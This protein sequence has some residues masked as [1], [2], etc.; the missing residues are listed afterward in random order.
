MIPTCIKQHNCVFGRIAPC[1]TFD[2]SVLSRLGRTCHPGAVFGVPYRLRLC[3]DKANREGK[4]VVVGGVTLAPIIEYPQ[5]DHDH[6]LVECVSG[7]AGE[8]TT[9]LLG[10]EP[11]LGRAVEDEG[12]V[13]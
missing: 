3:G 4:A 7:E 9:G 11:W 2:A 1:E 8:F 13:E 10:R 5:Q 12:G 6:H